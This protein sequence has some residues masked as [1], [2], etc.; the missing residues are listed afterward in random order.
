MVPRGMQGPLPS[1]GLG[2]RDA[3]GPP[4]TGSMIQHAQGGM[5]GPSS[6]SHGNMPN[7]YGMQGP[8]GGMHGSQGN[9][10]GPPE[11]LQ[12]PPYLQHQVGS[13]PQT[14]PAP[15]SS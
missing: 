12:A 1:R 4:H 7:N 5:M 6:R 14:G 8:P 15:D 10:Q 13:G 3:Q 2:P 11:G 9:V